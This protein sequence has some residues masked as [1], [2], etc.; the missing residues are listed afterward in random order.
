MP[1]ATPSRLLGTLVLSIALVACGGDPE[2]G[3]G[4]NKSGEANGGS[5]GSAGNGTMI[6][7]GATSN[8][9]EPLT[10]ED[11]GAECGKIADGCGDVLDC[12]GCDDGAL[13]GIVE[14]NTCTTLTDL[15]EP[16]DEVEACADKECGFAGDGC[17]G[18]YDC[19][20]CSGGQA[21]GA[22][23]PYQCDAADAF[24]EDECPA[25][26]TS[27]ASA[28]AGFAECG[29]IGNGC[30]GVLDCSDELGGCEAGAVCGLGGPNQ[31][32]TAESTCQPV[33]AADACDG[34]CGLVSNG[35]GVEIDG[36]VIDCSAYAPCPD[37]QSCGGAG[38]PNECGS[39]DGLCTPLEQATACAG[40]ACGSAGDGCEGS[41]TCG[42]CASDEM[43]EAGVCQPLCTPLS[44]AAACSGK[45]CGIVGDG[46]GGTYSCGTCG[47][48]ETC[49]LIVPFGCDA[50]PPPVCVPL[51]EAVAC[52]GKE[53]GTVYDGCGTAAA[54][55]ID[56]GGCGAGTYCGLQQPY[57]CD[58]P[59]PPSCDA[60]QSCADLG[61]S[62][63]I[64]V[65]DCGNTFDCAAEGRVCG[66]LE[67]CVGGISGPTACVSDGGSGDC[68]LCNAVPSCS[69]QSQPTKLSGRVVTPGRN[70][71]DTGN[72]VGVPNALVY[73]LR[74][75]DE[76]DLPAFSDG[77][78]AGG[79]SCQRCSEE[80]LGPVLASAVTDAFGEYTIEGNVPVGQEFLL[81]VKIGEFRRAE[82]RLLPA[83]AKCTTTTLTTSLPGNPTRLPRSRSDGIGANIPHIAI[84][85]GEAD[86]MECVFEKLGIDHAEFT[87]PA[88]GGRIH[89]YHSN[90]A[91]PDQQS[92]DCAACSTPLCRRNN[93]DWSSGQDETAAQNAFMAAL[94]DLRLFED[95]GRI[96]EYDMV[97]FDCQG[98]GWAHET[99]SDDAN[100]RD[101]VNRGG[102]MFASHYSR[103]WICDN[104]SAAYDGGSPHTTGLSAS[105]TFDCDGDGVNED[106]GTGIVSLGRPGVN[107]AKLLDFAAWLEHENAATLIG[108]RY[109]FAIT[110]PR[111]LA[112]AVGSFS[113]EFV[114]RELASSTSVQQY[115]FDTPYGA[116]EAAACGRVAYSGFHVSG[117]T[118]DAVFP[119]HCSGSLTAQEKV[120]LY[121][122]FD[123]GGCVGDEPEPP[124]CTPQACAAGSCGTLPDGCGGTQECT[125]AAGEICNGNSCEV[126]GCTKT[127]CAAQNAECGVIADGCGGVIDCGDCPAC[128][129]IDEA[130]ACAGVCGFVSDGCGSVYQCPLDCG[131]GVCSSGACTVETCVP[132]ACPAALECGYVSD[133]CD[134]VAFCGDCVAPEECGAGGQANMCDVP[135][136]DPLDCADLDAECGMIGDGCGEAVNCGPCPAGQI[137]GANGMANQ[138]GGCVPRTCADAGAECGAIGDGCGGVVECGP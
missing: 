86:S 28:E 126:P 100:V 70:D 125:C 11:L 114:Y 32:G 46:C 2:G 116:P 5:G 79:E 95:N 50:A 101:Y 78:P 113:E 3:K 121:A 132:A 38:V 77:I 92:A 51:T 49:G 127:S 64:A 112:T 19:G 45:S 110:D 87:R 21:C 17:E 136:C 133:G 25:E 124:Q 48:G 57:Q 131:A 123:L 12:G 7:P 83:G 9:C 84:S 82:H 105:G 30:G 104:G 4:S 98:A 60:A 109:E 118:A 96:D 67:A 20:S 117:G 97:V 106:N 80:D 88:L 69:G 137:C 130:T 56:C 93:C 103:H 94:A 59:T 44:K 53:C 41:T 99:A 15:C 91:W 135:V 62:C 34:K 54:N 129:P 111:D 107:T 47:L 16:I 37:G 81:V 42:S 24:T 90:G 26:I 74:S 1:F 68:P 33:S 52:A 120:L 119:N 36:G 14:N 29:I 66:S 75:N 122:L 23:E 85:T 115:S 61:W 71:A 63:G 10:C 76:A 13:C 73:I 89:L 22:Q 39:G 102:R 55:T 8:N 108:G 134:G 18:I 65:D 138:C 72:Q 128:E 35:C 40:I 27:C 31:C 6:D 58:A 43:C